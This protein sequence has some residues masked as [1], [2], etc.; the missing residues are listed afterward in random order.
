[1]KSKAPKAKGDAKRTKRSAGSQQR[2]VSRLIACLPTT[3]LDP[4]LTGPQAVIETKGPWG[5]RDIENI[6]GAIRKRMNSE[7]ANEKGQR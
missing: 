3:W 2:V 5:C 1:M 7:A 6:I 4:I